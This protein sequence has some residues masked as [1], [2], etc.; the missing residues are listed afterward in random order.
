MFIIYFFL[1]I[2]L[3]LIFSLLFTI[4]E[5]ETHKY[6]NNFNYKYIKY[7]NQV[8][9]ILLYD[10]IYKLIA[11]KKPLQLKKEYEEENETN[12]N[13]PKNYSE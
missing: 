5:N 3:F 4:K 13:K 6:L 9:I 7:F 10:Y 8:E 2:Y 12:N 1:I 11:I